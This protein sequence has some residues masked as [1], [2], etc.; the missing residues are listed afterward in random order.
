LPYWRRHTDG[1]GTWKGDGPPGEDLAAL[2]RGIGRDPGAE[3]HLWPFYTTLSAD[4]R[5][6]ADLRAEH[7]A[8][9]LYGVHQQSRPRPM[10]REGIGVGTAVLALRGSG[11]FSPEA[12]DRRF[13]AA[14]TATSLAEASAHLRGLVTQLRSIDQP[15]D[16]TRLF[17]DLRDWQY[18]DRLSGVRRRW[19]G[20]Y[21]TPTPDAR[22][23]GEAGES[24][25][26][27]ATPEP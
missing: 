24:S 20:Q 13:G 2:R 10:H 1:N 9:T 17:R 12:V 21:F 23:S 8:L 11:K 7:V 6:S 5:I 25:G 19:G 14:A 27:A 3:P 22:D 15:L 16:Y 4:G 18:P 26:S